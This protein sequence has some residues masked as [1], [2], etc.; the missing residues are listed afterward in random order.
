MKDAYFMKKAIV[1]PQ[2]AVDC[3]NEPFDDRAQGK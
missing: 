1:F 3:G 2:A